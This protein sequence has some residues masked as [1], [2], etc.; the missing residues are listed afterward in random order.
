MKVSAAESQVLEAD[1][2]REHGD[3][4]GAQPGRSHSAGVQ[5]TERT[6]RPDAVPRTDR[7]RD[8][9]AVERLA[10][11]HRI[12][13]QEPHL[14]RRATRVRICVTYFWPHRLNYLHL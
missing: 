3:G 1:N 10:Q 9:G 7:P 14:R 5:A 2:H 4:Q 6:R 12:R 11:E 13:P 8:T